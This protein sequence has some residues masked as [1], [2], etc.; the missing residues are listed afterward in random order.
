VR[1]LTASTTE[2]SSAVFDGFT[3]IVSGSD[4]I[5][6]TVAG[7]GT[8][9]YG[10]EGGPATS[11][12]L[13]NATSIAVDAA[14]NLFISDR[15]HNRVRKVTPAGVISTVAGN[16]QI[17]TGVLGGPATM[18]SFANLQGIGVDAVGNLFIADGANN[19]I[20]KVDL[21]GI[22]TRFAGTGQFGF[23]GDEGPAT[24]ARLN[25]PTQVQ[26]DFAGNV[27]I[28]DTNNQ[29]IRKVS[30]DGI[31]HTVAGGG[32]QTGP[33]ANGLPA[34]SVALDNI[35]D[36]AI[37]AAGNLYLV[38]GIVV[39]KVT[40]AGILTIVAGILAPGAQGFSGDGGP[41]NAAKVFNPL[42]LATN[43][44]GD[45]FI[46]DTQ[47]LRI[48][49][50]NPAGV[51]T[52]VAGTGEYGFSGD[53]GPATA[54]RMISPTDV[55]VDADGNLYIADPSVR[56]IRKVTYYLPGISTVT[57]L[58]APPATS[59]TAS[60]RGV[61]LTGATA[62]TFSGSGV[63]A[64]I[65]PGGTSTVLPVTITVAPGALPVTRSLTVTTGAGT[66]PSFE[67]FAVLS[68]RTRGQITSQ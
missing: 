66:S 62:A 31:I 42:G 50:V 30:T 13:D 47:N 3:V 59:I 33:A 67:G 2:A 65:L 68:S 40:P 22:V 23:E 20:L 5:I 63:T 7:D 14:G 44:A 51:I 39:E 8:T 54:A 34:T 58:S 45:L 52:T 46:A 35:A 64:A 21:A 32:F 56:R 57:P 4:G 60:I 6:T 41:A 24:A 17:G 37:D 1:T 11:T 29:R 19:R 43:S 12:G 15:N 25:F 28:A 27:F 49:K 10:G 61:A 48:R 26:V 55:A 16:G 36:I 9:A 53:G 18:V 38:N